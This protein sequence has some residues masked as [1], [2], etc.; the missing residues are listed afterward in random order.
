MHR[1]E[2]NKYLMITARC[3]FQMPVLSHMGG[4]DQC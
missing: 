1:Q 4:L 2:G 3:M